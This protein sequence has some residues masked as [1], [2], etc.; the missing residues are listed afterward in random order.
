MQE[1]ALR[2]AFPGH[3]RLD[4]TA[5]VR[6]DD[7]RLLLLNLAVIKAVHPEDAVFGL[8]V[9]Q[10][11][12]HRDPLALEIHRVLIHKTFLKN[13]VIR[14]SHLSISPFS[15][16]MGRIRTPPHAV[17]HLLFRRSA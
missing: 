5:A 8:G 16:S 3:M 1:H 9:D 4:E 13:S 14:V 2:P 7:C 11:A 15:P 17:N 6:P 12:Y 10:A